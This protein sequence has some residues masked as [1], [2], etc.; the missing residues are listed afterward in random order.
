MRSLTMEK[1]DFSEI[2]DTCKWESPDYEPWFPVSEKSNPLTRDIDKSSP[3]HIVRLLAACDAQMFQKDTGTSYQRL[4]SD[5]VVLTMLEVARTVEQI[6][7]DPEDSLVVLSGC[8]TSGRLAFLMASCFNRA[9]RDRQQNTVYCYIIAGGDRALLTSQEASEDDPKLGM[10]TLEKLCEGKRRVLFIG[11]SCGLSAPFVAGQ[12]D[13]CLKHPDIYTPVLVGF[14]PV[15]QAREETMPGYSLTFREVVQR[16]EEQRG[17]RAFIINPAVGPEAISGSSRMK[18]GSATKILLETIL[19]AAHTA[20]FTNTHVTRRV[21]LDMMRGYERVYSVTYSHSDQ[22]ATLLQTAGLSLQCGGRVCYLSWGSLGLVGLIDASECI[23]TFGAD[24]EDI[25]GFISGGY[26]DMD[27]IEGDLTSLGSQFCIAHEDFV[28]LVLPTLSDRDTVLL[29]YTCHDDVGDVEKMV[30]RVRE[31]TSNLHSLYHGLEGDTAVDSIGLLCSSVLNITWPSSSTVH[32]WELS[33]KLVLNAVS[34]GS[35]VLKGK[36]YRNHMVDLQV[37]N[38]KLYHRAIHIL[39]KM[40]GVSL[41]Q[42]EEALLKAIYHVEQLPEDITSAGVTTHTLTA[43]RRNRVVP[44]ALVCLLIGC[45]L[46]EAESRLESHPVVR[47]AVEACLTSSQHL[48]SSAG[49][50]NSTNH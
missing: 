5:S 42:C 24:Y 49:D 25:R 45:S 14:N 21:L 6:L 46:S 18:G 22:I 15:T 47:D 31:K 48:T 38:S 43:S 20:A 37:T 39:Q 1:R 30:H 19:A 23:P 13:F 44:L 9:L 36:I 17:Q 29:L 4:F 34:T 28:S 32:M 7:R 33:S 40:S 27:N 8:G 50:Q 35:H 2:S 16:M 26:Q 12:L 10:L 11:I 41:T 3:N